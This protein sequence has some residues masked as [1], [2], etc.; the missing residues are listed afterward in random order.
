MLE[1]IFR[2]R[3]GIPY[4]LLAWRLEAGVDFF[5]TLCIKTTMAMYSCKKVEGGRGER[6][7][8]EE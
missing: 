1:V 4:Q 5:S 6:R 2:L 3:P 7:R 8:H